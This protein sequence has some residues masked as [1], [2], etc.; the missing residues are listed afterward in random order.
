[1]L[2]IPV[3]GDVMTYLIDATYN[4]LDSSSITQAEMQGRNRAWAYLAAIQT[5]PGYEKAYIVSTGPKFG[6]RESRHINGHYRVT[7][8][9]VTSGA[10]HDDVIALGAW[11]IEYHPEDDQPVIWK[12]IQDDGTFDIPLRALTSQNTPN[13]YGAGRLVDGDGGG[14]SA[15]RVMGTSFAT[16]QAAGVAAALF[17]PGTHSVA[18]ASSAG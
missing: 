17:T 12:L 10:R 8:E 13:L 11:P 16:G 18:G 4:A 15:L 5:I 14:G 7:E 6:T 1:M 9:D 2:P 3:L